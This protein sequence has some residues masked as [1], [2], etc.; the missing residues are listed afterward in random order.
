MY[1][2]LRL[3]ETQPPYTYVYGKDA[4]IR[5][6]D[7]CAEREGTLL[8]G[9]GYEA[10]R[11]K[12]QAGS[13]GDAEK[14]MENALLTLKAGRFSLETLEWACLRIET[15]LSEVV[16]ENKLQEAFPH[17]F[18]TTLDHAKISYIKHQVTIHQTVHHLFIS[19]DPSKD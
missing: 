16:L 8:P 1:K 12:I 18:S 11:N 4:I 19:L 13:P 2:Y 6:E 3:S 14:W 10:L 7:V 5:H 9:V 17:V 15:V